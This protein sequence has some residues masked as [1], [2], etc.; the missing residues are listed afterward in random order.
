MLEPEILCMAK[1]EQATLELMY[2]KILKR[3]H[4]WGKKCHAWLH[5]MNHAVVELEP[6]YMANTP[7]QATMATIK[8]LTFEFQ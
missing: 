5:N 4:G 7:K 8:F 2:G 1:Y 3:R 6:L